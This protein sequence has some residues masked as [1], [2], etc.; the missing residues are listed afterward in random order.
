MLAQVEDLRLRYRRAVLQAETQVKEVE[1]L[2]SQLLLQT[3]LTETEM[4]P[5][6]R[7]LC[8]EIDTWKRLKEPISTNLELGEDLRELSFRLERTQF[9][10]SRLGDML[11]LS[12]AQREDQQSLLTHLQSELL[13]QTRL[14]TTQNQWLETAESTEISLKEEVRSLQSQIEDLEMRCNEHISE[15]RR[16]QQLVV[17]LNSA[18]KRILEVHNEEIQTIQ[19]NFL[20]DLANAKK[21]WEEENSRQFETVKNRVKS[22]EMELEAE[23]EARKTDRTSLEL[24]ETARAELAVKLDEL[25]SKVNSL[26]S[27]LSE[28]KNGVSRAVTP[29]VHSKTESVLRQVETPPV[30]PTDDLPTLIKSLEQENLQG[31][32]QNWSPPQPLSRD[33]LPIS[34]AQLQSIAQL[35]SLTSEK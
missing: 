31:K 29:Q 15:K 1:Q 9:Q 24:A 34:E 18:E 25:Q 17:D 5:E 12:E 27:Q 14:I 23:V 11:A 33:S 16:L 26:T 2:L 19:L 30:H 3:T 35:Q 8:R 10:V 32:Q 20:K 21:R 22:A 6:L 13:D 28:V 7:S 4:P